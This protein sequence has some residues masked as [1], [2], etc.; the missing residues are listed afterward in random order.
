[1]LKKVIKRLWPN[2]FMDIFLDGQDH[3]VNRIIAQGH[4]IATTKSENGIDTLVRIGVTNRELRRK[5]KKFN[6]GRTASK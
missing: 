4:I 5:S 1:M 3:L 6:T 2:T